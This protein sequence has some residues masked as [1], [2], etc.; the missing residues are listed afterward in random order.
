MMTKFTLRRLVV[1]ATSSNVGTFRKRG[2]S[3]RST[4]A[5]YL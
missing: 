1:A 5:I 3:A 2:A 4:F